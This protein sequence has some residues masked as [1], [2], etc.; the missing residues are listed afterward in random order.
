MVCLVWGI[1]S[2]C[3]GAGFFFFLFFLKISHFK[4]V[5]P[6]LTSVIDFERLM[7]RKS[8]GEIWGRLLDWRQRESLKG[9]DRGELDSGWRRRHREPLLLLTTRVQTDPPRSN[10]AACGHRDAVLPPPVRAGRALHRPGLGRCHRRALGPQTP[11]VPAEVSGGCRRKT[12]ME[13]AGTRP[14]L[15]RT[16]QLSP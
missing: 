15:L 7:V 6:P 2:A 16:P 4:I 14:S 5:S 9:G 8:T 11:P 1:S 10:S 12:G 3:V 13:M